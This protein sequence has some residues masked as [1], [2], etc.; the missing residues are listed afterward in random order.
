[1]RSLEPSSSITVPGPD[2]VPAMPANALDWAWL[3][4]AAKA[5]KKNATAAYVSR[6]A[7]AQN[8][9]VWLAL[10]T[11]RFPSTAARDTS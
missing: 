7:L 6:R 9:E 5:V 4:E 1:M 11:G 3:V 10:L 2:Q 8:S